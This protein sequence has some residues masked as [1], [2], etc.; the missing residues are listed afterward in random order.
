MT[1]ANETLALLQNAQD[2]RLDAPKPKPTSDVLV[3]VAASMVTIDGKA[4]RVMV[5]SWGYDQTNTDFYA[6]VKETKTTV[7]LR[8]LGTVGVEYNGR[9][10]FARKVVP[11]DFWHD[12]YGGETK[13]KRKVNAP[14]EPLSC[15]GVNDCGWTTQWDGRPQ[16]ETSYH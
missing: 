10:P 8:R 12:L 14:G 9:D 3:E 2:Q 6:V 15:S 1:A 13:R 16:T 11:G 5:H 7:T 4:H